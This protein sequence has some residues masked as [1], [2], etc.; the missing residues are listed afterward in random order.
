MLPPGHSTVSL[1]QKNK[2]IL[3]KARVADFVRSINPQPS[4]LEYAE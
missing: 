2:L 3:E 1:K 4:I